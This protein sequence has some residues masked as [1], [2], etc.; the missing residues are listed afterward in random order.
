M[1]EGSKGPEFNIP[2]EGAGPEGAKEE[3]KEEKGE[4]W[5]AIDQNAFNTKINKFNR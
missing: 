3:E 2:S 5:K 1:E 4:K